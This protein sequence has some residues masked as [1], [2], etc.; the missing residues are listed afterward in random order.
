MND[1]TARHGRSATTTIPRQILAPR[2]VENASE[3]CACGRHAVARRRKPTSVSRWG[4]PEPVCDVCAAELDDLRERC[5][6]GCAEVD[7]A[8]L[9]F[10]RIAA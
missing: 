3:R 5:A 1:E 4:L 7:R 9:R 10:R 6:W 8:V 2:A